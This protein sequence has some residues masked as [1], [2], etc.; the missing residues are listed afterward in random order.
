MRNS[1]IRAIIIGFLPLVFV[2]F[3]LVIFKNIL[4]TFILY[5]IIICMVLP[6]INYYFWDHKP[7]PLS[8][9]LGL[10]RKD[11]RSILQGILIGAVFFIGII[12]F[13]DFVHFNFLDKKHINNILNSLGFSSN[14]FIYFAIYFILI[15]SVLEELFW[16]GYLYYQFGKSIRIPFSSVIISFFFIQYHFF[17]IG[18]I[19]SV[20]VAFVFIPVIFIVSV[21]WCYL[22]HINSN[23]YAPLISHIMADMALIMVFYKYLLI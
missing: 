15:N 2:F 10:G 19:F 21:I 13:F 23:I 18:L 14:I 1:L 11:K 17:V 5:H 12:I 22:R 6:V 7:A 3:G 20:Q 9:M 4:I 16:R 8:E